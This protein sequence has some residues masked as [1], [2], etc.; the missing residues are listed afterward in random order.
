MVRAEAQPRR[1][2][3]HGRPATPLQPHLAEDDQGRRLV[4]ALNLGQVSPGD[5]VQRVAHGERWLVTAPLSR[6]RRG[7]PWLPLAAV[8]ARM[9]RGRDVPMA[10]GDLLVR[11]LR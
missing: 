3:L 8:G 11:D 7:W 2:V 1:E 5:P 9:Q 4:N 6:P 10:C